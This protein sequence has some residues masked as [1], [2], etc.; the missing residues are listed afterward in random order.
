MTTESKLAKR[1]KE[2]GYK[3]TLARLAVIDVLES[4]SEHLNHSQILVEGQKCYAK[5]SQATV[6]RTMELLVELGFMRPL[7]LNDPTQ[8]FISAKGGHHH[9]ICTG[10]DTTIEFD[11]C[12]A[13]H[14]LQ[15]LSAQHN[16]QIHSHLLEFRGVCADCAVG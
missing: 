6:Y 8:R 2:A 14:L 15:E 3:L 9:L 12:N 13:S 10:C 4:N 16:F 7:Y 5:L 11:Q 1:L